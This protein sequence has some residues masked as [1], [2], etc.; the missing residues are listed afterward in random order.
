MNET[1]APAKTLPRPKGIFVNFLDAVREGKTETASNFDYGTR[2][3]EFSLLGNLA[4]H[5][6]VGR[7]IE[8]DGPGMKVTNI[9]ELN[10]WVKRENRKGWNL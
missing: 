10:A 4:M 8:W 3:T 5:A 6:G 2:L 9:P 7:K 1:K